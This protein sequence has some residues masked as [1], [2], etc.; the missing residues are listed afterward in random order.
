MMMSESHY[1]S[2]SDTDSSDDNSVTK[3]KTIKTLDLSNS[4]FKTYLQSQ[5]STSSP[6]PTPTDL[7]KIKSFLTNTSGCCLICLE[8]IRLSDPTWSCSS[9]CFTV[10]H[11]VCIQ[12]W[13]RQSS[14]S[15][16]ARALTRLPVT[17]ER[18]TETA[19]W[20]CPKCRSEYSSSM[21][22]R[23]YLCYCGKLKDPPSDNPW[24]LPHSCG[25]TCGR[26]LRPECG[27][28]CLL[29]C[30]PGPCPPCPKLTKN[31]CFCG[32]VS[33]VRRCGHKNFSCDN[34]CFKLLECTIHKCNVICHDGV[35]PPCAEQSMYAC[36]CGSVHELRKCS[37]RD[38]RCE[39]KCDKMLD[40]G[41]HSCDKGCHYEGECG[42]CPLQGKRTCPCG[43]KGYEGLACD[44]A[45]PLCGGTCDKLLNCQYHRCPERCH[46]G[47]CLATCRRVV[48]KSCRCGVMKKE[49][50]C[51]QD[52]T[53]ERKCIKIRDCGRHGCRRRCC[54]GDCPPCA[55][56]CGKK[57]RCR[58]HRCPSPCHLGPC[59][60]CPL[61]VTI[62][63]ACGETRFEVRICDFLVMGLL[64]FSH[65][66]S[67][68]PVVPC[69]TEKDQK[70]PRCRKLCQKTPLCSHV[71]V[72]KPHRCH[73]GPCPPC[74]MVCEENFCCG[75][76]CKL[77]CHGPKPPPNPEF[78][79][80]PTKKQLSQKLEGTPGSPC[81][82][83]P[84]LIWIS[85]F[86]KHL[87]AEKRVV[88][89]TKK[90]F[91]CENL[92]GNPLSCGNHYCTHR[93]HAVKNGTCEECK[94]R[95]QKERTTLPCPHPCPLK[96]HPGDCPPCKTLIKRSCHCGSLVHVFECSYFNTLSK[97]D[98]ITVRSCK[99][100]CHRKL[101]YC[102]HLCPET[103]HI[104][105][106]PSPEKCCKKVTVRC[107]CQTLKKE[108]LCKDVQSAYRDAGSDLSAVSKSHFGLGLLPCNA[109]C[110]R[111]VQAAESVLKSRKPKVKEEKETQTDET[112]LKRKKRRERVQQTEQVPTFQKFIATAK[113]VA[114]ILAIVLALIGGTYFCYKGLLKLN[115]W[116]NALDEQRQKQGPRRI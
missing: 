37:E 70:P 19:T 106:C 26:A 84:E 6:T 88:C 66:Y 47:E 114:I 55:E 40:C 54:D 62:L 23:E 38:F 100:P 85:C 46:N 5:S 115:D 99:G 92:C 87:G 90:S 108:W 63:C 45:A 14:A 113:L 81:Q 39:G 107:K 64:V 24:I 76:S 48:T 21:I 102:T 2:F 68:H 96:C 73:Y 74:R 36:H 51:F 98:Q 11:L 34:P 93:C 60:P 89:S 105:S 79:L 3:S 78:N 44:V 112:L 10:F 72:S 52:L 75:H 58:N 17:Q 77:R 110:E 4:I 116:M 27:H 67:L 22:P 49:V 28:H 86:G 33:D 16:A 57:L 29:L 1:S 91:A 82:P 35:C 8:R 31:H 9:L 103:C 13:A 7:S 53:C 41:K 111:K 56:V 109:E 94:L 71:S 12:S 18:A 43:K 69:G 95:C 32:K 61:M 104:G 20:N 50:P 42:K 101:P 25:E 65:A 80:K 59:S 30:H 15:S 83:C 97:E